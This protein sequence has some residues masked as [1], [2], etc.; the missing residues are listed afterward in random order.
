MNT[1]TDPPDKTQASASPETSGARVVPNAPQARR[2]WYASTWLIIAYSAFLMVIFCI[3]G[4]I[5]Y[6]GTVREAIQKTFQGLGPQSTPAETPTVTA[7]PT[8]APLLVPQACVIVWVEHPADD[9]GKKSRARVW[10]RYVS[11]E[12]KAS[13]MTPRQFYELVVEHNPHL[14]QD[15]YEFKQGKKYLLPECQ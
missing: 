14:V 9:L 2:P 11:A 7:S 1:P 5:P 4:F 13:G 8:A 6:T 10:E 3:I 12:V 15:D